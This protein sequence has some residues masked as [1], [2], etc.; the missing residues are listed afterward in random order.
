MLWKRRQV[1]S[2]DPIEGRHRRTAGPREGRLS[3]TCGGKK[4]FEVLD[5]GRLQLGNMLQV[6]A[7]SLQSIW[8]LSKAYKMYC[9]LC[10]KILPLQWV[11]SLGC[12]A[13]EPDR[14]FCSSQ[15][16]EANNA[17]AGLAFFFEAFALSSSS[18][19]STTSSA[20]L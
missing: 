18:S 8:H 10:D 4:R 13:F 12:L 1:R 15:S 9:T 6:A 7:I 3:H 2:F 16:C 20:S 11:V 17:Q 19:S 5:S 14:F